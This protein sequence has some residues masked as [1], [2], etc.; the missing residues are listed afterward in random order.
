MTESES[1]KETIL[2]KGWED[3]AFN[4]IKAGSLIESIEVDVLLGVTRIYY[5]KKRKGEL[6]PS[7]EK[8]KHS[9]ITGLQTFVFAKEE[10][11]Q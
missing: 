2:C 9:Q 10:A 3:Y 7:L 11:E 4:L 6:H 1:L 8:V 5:K